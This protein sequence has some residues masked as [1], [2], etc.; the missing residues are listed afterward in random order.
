M[1]NVRGRAKLGDMTITINSTIFI[2][3]TQISQ[4][5]SKVILIY[6]LMIGVKGSYGMTNSV[7][8]DQTDPT[9]QSDLHWHSLLRLIFLSIG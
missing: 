7:D 1:R 9:E 5:I 6:S 8:P 2:Q 4:F 3:N